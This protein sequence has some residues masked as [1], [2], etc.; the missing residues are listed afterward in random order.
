M[1]CPWKEEGTAMAGVPRYSIYP[2][3]CS[4][5]SSPPPPTLLS[6]REEVHNPE[7]RD[8][9]PATSPWRGWACGKLPYDNR[10]I[11]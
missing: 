3:A 9:G 4:V 5:Q 11:R 7:D 1:I 10:L 6:P 8:E 2:V